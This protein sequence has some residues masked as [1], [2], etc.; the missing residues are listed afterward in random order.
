VPPPQGFAQKPTRASLA[1]PDFMHAPMTNPYAIFD[2][3]AKI[4]EMIVQQAIW[5]G[6]HLSFLVS[7]ASWG[8]MPVFQNDA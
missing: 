2:K 7:S 6:K 8:Q 1:L 4:S 3:S 5:V